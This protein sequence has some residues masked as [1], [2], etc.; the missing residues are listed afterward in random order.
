MAVCVNEHIGKN[1]RTLANEGVKL[2]LFQ[3]EPTN[4]CNGRCWYCPQPTL[5][6]PKGFMDGATFDAVLQV[7]KYP[8][9]H[10]H[11]YS[12]PLM[13]RGILHMIA[14]A[15]A[16]GFRVGFSTNGSLLTQPKLQALAEAGLAWLRLH[17][18]PHNVRLA[19]FEVPEGL[20]AT[21]HRV[22]SEGPEDVPEKGMTSF[23]GAIEG[24]PEERHGD[25]QCS[26]LGY[27]GGVDWQCVLW[28]GT[29][30]LCCVDAEGGGKAGRGGLCDTCRGY[31]FRGPED[32]GNYDG[33]G[34]FDA[35]G[36]PK[37]EAGK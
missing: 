29:V 21:E 30:T 15:T 7:A 1:I 3:V 31:V 26:F 33:N 10:L 13:H 5:K 23:A 6:R 22:G 9:F 4:H 25:D 19:D 12:E 37:G 28:D 2:N 11:G 18:G 24:L 27:P 32:W 8:A 36:R 34:F 20:L 16:Q 35:S 14:R 17:V